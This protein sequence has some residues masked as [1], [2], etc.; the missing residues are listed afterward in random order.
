M[1]LVL[2]AALPAVGLSWYAMKN[3]LQDFAYRIDIGPAVYLIAIFGAVTIAF[4]TVAYHAL[5]AG[6]TNPVDS[7]KEE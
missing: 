2:I 4:M 1:V 6:F 5:K 7:L 3:W